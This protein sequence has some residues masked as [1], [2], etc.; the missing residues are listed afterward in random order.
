MNRI[1]PSAFGLALGILWAGIAFLLVILATYT[2]YGT[3]VV[4]LLE[5]IFLGVEA[6][7]LG[8]LIALPWAFADGF[9]GG[10]ILAWLYNRFVN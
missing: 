5:T 1:N 4:E 7:W 8:A 9:L 6:S 10:F 2:G 3:S